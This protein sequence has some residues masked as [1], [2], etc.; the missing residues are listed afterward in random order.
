MKVYIILLISIITLS[1][2]TS[3]TIYK[4]DGTYVEA[5]IL[6]SDSNNVYIKT[7]AGEEPIN[8]TLITDIDHPGNVSAVVGLLLIGSAG[9]NAYAAS[10]TYYETRAIYVAGAVI[11]G[12][13]GISM[14]FGGLAIWTHSKDALASNFSSLNKDTFIKP[15]IYYTN[16]QPSYGLGYCKRF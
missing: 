14:L 15:Q 5:T 10:Q 7:Y 1:C 6:R 8:K 13:V 11:E 2:G 3:A 16:N 12:I 4:K 9:L